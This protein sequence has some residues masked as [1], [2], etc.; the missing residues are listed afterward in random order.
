MKFGNL[1]NLILPNFIGFLHLPI[2]RIKKSKG[3]GKKIRDDE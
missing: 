2:F 3:D 1:E